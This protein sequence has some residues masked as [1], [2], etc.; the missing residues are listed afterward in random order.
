MIQSTI[1]DCLARIKIIAQDFTLFRSNKTSKLYSDYSDFFFQD[2][3]PA[4]LDFQP[5][6]ESG[7]LSSS[8]V[9]QGTRA[10]K[11]AG[12]RAYMPA[13]TNEVIL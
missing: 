10:H 3:M 9:G 13:G 11:T 7:C 8:G 6:W 12:N 4:R 5:F 1:I 2:C